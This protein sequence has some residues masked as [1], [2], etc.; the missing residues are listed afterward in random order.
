MKSLTPQRRVALLVLVAASAAALGYVTVVHRAHDDDLQLYGNIDI[1]DV[2]LGFRVAGKVAVVNVDEGESVQVG[3]VM[4]G[5]DS[6]PLKLQQDEALANAAAISARV[7]L[8]RSGYRSE[9]VAQARAMLAERRAALTNAQQQYARQQQLK[10]TGAVA[11]RTYEDAAASRDQAQARLVSAEAA[12]SSLQNGYRKQEIAEAQA[13][14]KR[15]L[16]LAAQATQR[17]E[18]AVL[19][20]PADGTV[21]TRAIEPGAILAAGASAFTL[22]LRAPIWARV[23]VAEADLGKVPSGQRVL[24]YTDSRPDQPY[25]GHIGFVSPTAEFTPKNVETTDLRTSLVYRARVIVTDSDPGLRQGMPV[26]V[27]LDRAT[28]A[29]DRP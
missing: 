3:Q 2:T 16:S 8:L 29:K 22:S 10:D 21:L 20:A 4:A 19:V 12:L 6:V 17:L 14:E 15:A 1:R 25:H 5:L 26:S 11:V 23:Y 7:A 9:E 18:D 24:L 13:N 27:R 28:A